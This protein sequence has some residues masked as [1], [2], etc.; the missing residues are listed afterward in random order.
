MKE[1]KALL[2]FLV[3]DQMQ[4]RRGNASNLKFI[5]MKEKR[6]RPLSIPRS[7]FSTAA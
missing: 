5:E 7:S 4:L 2:L 6:S 1:L 3:N